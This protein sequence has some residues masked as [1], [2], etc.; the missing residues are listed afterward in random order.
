[1][2]SLTFTHRNDS[3]KIGL[4][5]FGQNTSSFKSDLA[6]N[7]RTR[8]QLSSDD[9]MFLHSES[10]GTIQFDD[11]FGKLKS[12]RQSIEFKVQSVRQFHCPSIKPPGFPPHA[13]SSSRVEFF[14]RIEKLGLRAIINL[15]DA[16]DVNVARGAFLNSKAFKSLFAK[17]EYEILTDAKLQVIYKG[18]FLA[19][20]YKQSDVVSIS[21]GNIKRIDSEGK[22]LEGKLHQSLA[23]A[24]AKDQEPSVKYRAQLPESGERLKYVKAFLQARYSIYFN[25][26]E[27]KLIKRFVRDNSTEIYELLKKGH[28]FTGNNSS[29]MRML[30]LVIRLNES[31]AAPVG[32]SLENQAEP[33]MKP[34]NGFT[35]DSGGQPK[36]QLTSSILPEINE[37]HTLSDQVS[38][39]KSK[40]LLES[41]KD[42][43]QDFSILHRKNTFPPLQISS[44]R[45]MKNMTIDWPYNLLDSNQFDS[46]V[47]EMTFDLRKSKKTDTKEDSLKT[48]HFS[49][50]IS[51][52]ATHVFKDQ[53]SSEKPA[54]R[55]F[56]SLQNSSTI[57]FPKITIDMVSLAQSADANRTPPN[58]NGL[59]SSQKMGF[60]SLTLPVSSCT[61]S[62]QL[63]DSRDNHKI[64]RT[65]FHRE[66]SFKAIKPQS[67]EDV[68]P[69]ANVPGKPNEPT[70]DE[71]RQLSPASK[72]CFTS[73]ENLADVIPETSP[74][75]GQ[76]LV[77]VRPPNV[78]S[79]G[80][81]ANDS[82]CSLYNQEVSMDSQPA[83]S[84]KVFDQQSS[85]KDENPK[86]EQKANKLKN[87]ART[88]SNSKELW[89]INMMIPLN[90]AHLKR[91]SDTT[92][93]KQAL[94]NNAKKFSQ[95]HE[96][97]EIINN[98][99]SMSNNCLKEKNGMDLSNS[100]V[101][102]LLFENEDH[103]SLSRHSSAQKS[104]A[105]RNHEPLKYQQT[106]QPQLSA[107][108][109]IE[110]LSLSDQLPNEKKLSTKTDTGSQ[111]NLKRLLIQKYRDF[112]EEQLKARREFQHKLINASFLN[113]SPI[114]RGLSPIHSHYNSPKYES[115]YSPEFSPKVSEVNLGKFSSQ[116]FSRFTDSAF[117]LQPMPV[118]EFESDQ[119]VFADD[120]GDY[121]RDYTRFFPKM[122]FDSYPL[123]SPHDLSRNRSLTNFAADNLLRLAD[124]DVYEVKSRR[125]NDELFK[126]EDSPGNLEFQMKIA[127]Q[128][129][130]DSVT[131]C[132][133]TCL[134]EHQD[135]VAEFSFLLS[136][137]W[138]QQMIKGILSI[139]F[140]KE[141]FEMGD[142]F[143]ESVFD[144]FSN[145]RNL[146]RRLH[147]TRR[148]LAGLS[149]STLSRHNRL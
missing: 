42:D 51:E 37:K 127:R 44:K 72:L 68:D 96:H 136:F 101:S 119:K 123:L 55:D 7:L 46:K 31:Q 106:C 115:C 4:C 133:E 63:Q 3:L 58:T 126:F 82:N 18:Y 13:T 94:K 77:P 93:I 129:N 112:I 15:F 47:K 134:K 108:K 10:T 103:P 130:I 132:W 36:A 24:L 19:V 128:F 89:D 84:S 99:F 17:L 35:L 138:E 110:V 69:L 41:V 14:K 107:N 148:K 8:F 25:D 79:N 116:S 122:S 70:H 105:D 104:L 53:P 83:N 12:I 49:P 22:Y 117:V 48:P 11:L 140:L 80:Q 92:S 1:M 59:L 29:L 149:L 144:D 147:R 114:D 52:M 62:S 121:E 45:N 66:Y 50:I 33:S 98:I 100:V 145:D 39:S 120:F 73:F 109:T 43:N 56:D 125:V 143:L 54:I 141:R 85:I 61:N 26:K 81:Q 111:V 38:E 28:S 75:L 113:C 64:I 30:F 32:L 65:S 9:L 71:I 21:L 5:D 57:K 124:L 102:E 87:M 23:R 74:E 40:T 2:I 118:P 60:K 135:R 6:H 27:F 131:A 90:R 86:P 139:E 95:A 16:C 97:K 20:V 146:I 137:L 34:S 88:F 76:N 78:Q 91:F 67:S 142:R